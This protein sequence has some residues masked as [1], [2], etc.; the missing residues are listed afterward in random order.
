MFGMIQREHRAR[1]LQ[2][3]HYVLP[4]LD[5]PRRQDLERHPAAH[6]VGCRVDVAHASA[7]QQLAHQELR[8][9]LAAQGLALEER[10]GDVGGRAF[11]EIAGLLERGDQRLDFAAQFRIVC[12]GLVEEF[13]APL[14]RQFDRGLEYPVDLLKSFR[15]HRRAHRAR[16]SRYSQALASRQ[17]LSTVVSEI[18]ST[19]AASLLFMPPK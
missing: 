11:D 17:S 13:T 2:E 14:G 16:S 10:R 5:E 12:T 9:L 7:P 15:I 8:H 1:L 3:A 6:L 19:S 4:I 18:R